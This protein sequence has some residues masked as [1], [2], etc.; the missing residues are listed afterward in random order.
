MKQDKPSSSKIAPRT[1][2]RSNELE[3]LRQEILIITE[4]IMKLAKSRQEIA[5]RVAEVKSLGGL[6]V[7]DL[8]VEKK[9][10]EHV[11]EYVAKIGLDKRIAL[12]IIDILLDASKIAQRRRIFEQRII[13]FLR[14]YKIGSISIVGAGKMGGWFA[15]YFRAL[16]RKVILLDRRISFAKKRAEELGCEFANDIHT[17][18]RQ[19][20]LIFVAVPMSRT[21]QEIRRLQETL[22]RAGTKYRCKAIIETSSV[23]SE[24]LR[25]SFKRSKVPIIS[26]HP[27]FGESAP[28]FAKN[29]IA[30][31]K[32][33]ETQKHS[34]SLAF[35]KH[36]FP[37][38]N[39]FEIR[40][41][42]HDKQMALMLSL[43]HTL[44]LAFGDV[45]TRNSTLINNKR[46]VTPSYSAMKDFASKVFSENPDVYYE[47]QSMNKFTP[48]VLQKLGVSIAMLSRYF[49]Q[50]ERLK[51]KKLFYETKRKIGTNHNHN[52]G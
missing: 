47:I 51:F 1:N 36:L 43:P 12:E 4:S 40:A 41:E 33:G 21:S 13:S 23:K 15:S 18:A 42:A 24:V 50:G 22:D 25:R 11:S 35:V 7:E 37:Q 46:M 34:F 28:H 17:I 10:K 19:S 38:F 39:I 32:S 52:L 20:G 14:E 26:I 30:V 45:S 16:G 31:I 5:T 8:E 2:L 6:Q 3:H 27:L 29:T 48:K 44:A 49:E 9:L